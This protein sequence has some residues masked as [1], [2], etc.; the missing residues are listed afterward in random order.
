MTCVMHCRVYFIKPNVQ[1]TVTLATAFSAALNQYPTAR[2]M[3]VQ[4]WTEAINRA[5]AMYGCWAARAY[6]IRLYMLYWEIE[7]SS[8]LI[9]C[10]LYEELPTL[11]D[12]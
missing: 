11:M 10:M 4:E 2:I 8:N 9:G 12:G 1:S 3:S 6:G 5:V 7:V